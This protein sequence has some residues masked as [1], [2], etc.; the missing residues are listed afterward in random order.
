M[1]IHEMADATHPRMCKLAGA[2]GRGRGPCNMHAFQLVSR[3]SKD[4]HDSHPHTDKQTNKQRHAQLT[5]HRWSTAHC[6][7]WEG[8]L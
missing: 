4:M 2:G 8:C 3:R 7:S 6:S 1:N 5:I